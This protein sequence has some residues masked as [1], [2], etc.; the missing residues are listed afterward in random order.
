MQMS[1]SPKSYQK[2]W[3]FYD[4]TAFDF[5]NTYSR[6]LLPTGLHRVRLKINQ[7]G[8]PDP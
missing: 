5:T 4:A 7:N 3:L 6:Y 2:P 8:L 1:I